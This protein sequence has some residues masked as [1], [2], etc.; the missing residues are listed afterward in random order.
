MSPWNYPFQLALTPLIGVIAGGNCAVVKPSAYSPAVSAIIV[1]I[2]QECFSGRYISVIEGGREANRQLLKEKFDY[3]FFTAITGD[4]VSTH[5]P[6]K[7]AYKEC[8]IL[9]IGFRLYT[10]GLWH[11]KF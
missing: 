6:M 2:M 11:R 7:R 5:L 10:S 1:E 9:L 4:G 8:I 3:I